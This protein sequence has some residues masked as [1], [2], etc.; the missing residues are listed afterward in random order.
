M[1]EIKLILEKEDIE[2]FIKDK[3]GNDTEISGIPEDLTITVKVQDFI[4]RQPAQPERPSQPKKEEARLSDGSID[5]AKSG[6]ALKNREKTIPGSAMGRT[7]GN[8]PIF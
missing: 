5:A 2:K 1:I 6:L 4:Q 8:L 7:R 3:Y